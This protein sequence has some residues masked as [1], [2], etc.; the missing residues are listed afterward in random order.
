MGFRKSTRDVEA[1]GAAKEHTS[2][3][4][5]SGRGPGV[6][7]PGAGLSETPGFSLIL[8]C[9]DNILINVE[10]EDRG[11]KAKVESDWLGKEVAWET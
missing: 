2:E 4:R 6:R 5:G 11:R 10:I 3:A 8:S 1:Q 7:R 9:L